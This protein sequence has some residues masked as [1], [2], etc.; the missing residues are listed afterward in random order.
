MIAG[1]MNRLGINGLGKQKNTIEE[2]KAPEQEKVP[3][4]NPE[5]LKANEEL[6]NMS[7]DNR[8][9]AL[10]KNTAIISSEFLQFKDRIGC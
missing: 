2:T 1:I 4:T 3:P 5:L 9:D 6:N 7:K 8:T 10:L